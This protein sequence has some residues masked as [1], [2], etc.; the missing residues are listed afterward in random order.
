MSKIQLTDTVLEMIMKMVDGNPGAIMS[1]TEL[2]NNAETIDPQSAF[3]SISPIL[4]LDTNEI[5]GSDIYILF[6]DK[7]KRDSRKCLLLLRAVQLGLRP[8][9]WLQDLASDQLRRINISD[10]EWLEIDSA[11]CSELSEFQRPQQQRAS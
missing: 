5:Y 11:V 8:Q 10:D 2:M 6:N 9:G 4:S 1:I 7:C 3:G